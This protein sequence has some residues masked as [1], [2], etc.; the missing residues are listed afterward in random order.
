MEK[1]RWGVEHRKR[2]TMRQRHAKGNMVK[3]TQQQMYFLP[4]ETK[5]ASHC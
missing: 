5:E 4:L 2:D 3:A 1:R